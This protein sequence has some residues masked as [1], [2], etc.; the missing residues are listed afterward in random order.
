MEDKQATLDL[1]CETLQSTRSWHDIDFIE[2][3][4]EEYN[5]FAEVYLHGYKYPY[6]K[7]NISGDSCWALIKDVIEHLPQ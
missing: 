5:E 2:Y 7:I 6:K 3:I 1:L 4:E